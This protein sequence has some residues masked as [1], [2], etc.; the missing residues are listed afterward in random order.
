[1]AS[2]T[3]IS[4]PAQ[5]LQERTVRR[6]TRHILPFLFLLY[7]V[8]YLDRVNVSFASLEMT[9]DLG[10][11]N[12]QFG[13]AAGI[14]FIGYFLLEV[15]GAVLVEVWRVSRVEPPHHLRS[16]VGVV[17]ECLAVRIVQ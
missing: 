6:I 3:G 16:E 2:R 12:E 1:M 17:G 13:F 14:F 11:T 8:A 10:M 7:L 9:H 15:P 4:T 5:E